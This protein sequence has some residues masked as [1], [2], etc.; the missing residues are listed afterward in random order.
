MEWLK[1]VTELRGSVEKS[2]LTRA[3]QINK[4]G[5]Y[6]IG[7]E[8]EKN[9]SVENSLKLQIRPDKNNDHQ[10]T[11]YRGFMFCRRL[12]SFIVISDTT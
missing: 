7:K 3:Q 6:I 9:P 1:T 10:G 8:T 4:R 11:L 12:E 5:V 2:S